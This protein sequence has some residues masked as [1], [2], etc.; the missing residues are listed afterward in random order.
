MFKHFVLTRLSTIIKDSLASQMTLASTA[1]REWCFENQQ[2]FMGFMVES[3]TKTRET[4]KAPTRIAKG[5]T[6]KN[7]KGIKWNQLWWSR[8]QIHHICI[9]IRCLKLVQRHFDYSLEFLWVCIPFP[10]LPP[11]NFS[12]QA[13]QFEKSAVNL[14]GRSK[15][16]K[17]IPR[18]RLRSAGNVLPEVLL[19][20][21]IIVSTRQE[22]RG[23]PTHSI[24]RRKLAAAVADSMSSVLSATFAPQFTLVEH[25]K[26]YFSDHFSVHWHFS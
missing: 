19:S 9:F 2:R 17:F 23:D 3:E 13:I 12:A 6:I 1:R 5:W 15:K 4:S 11:L 18:C 24:E 26:R 8:I 20:N 25:H 22:Q 7:P 10:L 16:S 14:C 21:F